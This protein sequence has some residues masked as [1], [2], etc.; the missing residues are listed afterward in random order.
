MGCLLVL[1]ALFS[2]GWLTVL[3]ASVSSTPVVPTVESVI[4]SPV[5]VDSSGVEIA[6][7]ALARDSDADGCP[8]DETTTFR[9]SEAVNAFAV[10]A[11]PRGTMVFARMY[12]DGVP[13]EDTDR[14]TANRD[15][16]DV[17]VYFIFEPTVGAE[18]FDRGPYTI[19]FWVNDV[20][21]GSVR[22]VIQ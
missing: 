9:R 1:I 18:V 7:F 13:I 21:A 14:L 16:D 12:Y 3:P 19:E 22:L 6:R 8:Q 2:F 4:A 5:Y 20:S 10:G 17:C 15:Y 11:F